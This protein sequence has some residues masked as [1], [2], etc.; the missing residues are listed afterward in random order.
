MNKPSRWH[1]AT[2]KEWQQRATYLNAHGQRQDAPIV[3][4]T[5]QN[6]KATAPFAWL[7]CN[8]TRKLIRP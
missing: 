4:R 1:Q 7:H 3:I 8:N 6:S 2:V 5:M